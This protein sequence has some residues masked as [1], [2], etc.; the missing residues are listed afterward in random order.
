M[1]SECL[2]AA[3]P[4]SRRPLSC[5]SLVAYLQPG[6]GTPGRF[7]LHP[8]PRQCQARRADAR[9]TAVTQESEVVMKLFRPFAAALLLLLLAGSA[10]QDS[11]ADLAIPDLHEGK[12]T[13]LGTEIS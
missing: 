9:R 6:Q 12:F 3:A 11:E 1:P 5:L 4:A 10:V 8:P 13:I 7:R 2:F